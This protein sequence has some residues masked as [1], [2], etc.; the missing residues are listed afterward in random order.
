M[1]PLKQ[2]VVKDNKYIY[3]DFE[4][5]Q[6]TGIHVMNYCIAYDD[7]TKNIYR[8]QPD[9]IMIYHNRFNITNIELDK[10]NV[11]NIDDYFT[12]NVTYN[13]E[14]KGNGKVIDK[15][16]ETF[17]SNDFK[18]Y[19]FISHYGKG[20]DMNPILGWLGKNK[21][22]VNHFSSGFKINYIE[23]KKYRNKIYRFY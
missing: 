23:V 4:A 20:Y 13:D 18:G 19:T 15:F 7:Y 8:I 17:I 9:S 12:L 1:K 22:E 6:E 2:K 11:D 5:N 3:F 16:C 10:L 21:I 14:K